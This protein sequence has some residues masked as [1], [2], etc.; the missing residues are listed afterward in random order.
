MDECLGRQAGGVPGCGVRL[1]PLERVVGYLLPAIAPDDA[2][3]GAA[4]ELLVVGGALGVAVVL[5][6][7][8]VDRWRHDVV[9]AAR[10]EKQRRPV[11][12]VEVYVVLL[13]AWREVG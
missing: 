4:L 1:G 6:V 10:Y 12:V 8:L 13:V 11:L 3:V 2:V 7:G 5:D 9:L